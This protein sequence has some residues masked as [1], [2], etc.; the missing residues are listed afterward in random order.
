MSGA[1]VVEVAVSLVKPPLVCT[2]GLSGSGKTS[3]KVWAAP[4]ALWF[5]TPG[6]LITSVSTV[7]YQPQ[8]VVELDVSSATMATLASIMKER[9]K[10]KKPKMVVIDDFSMI[11]NRTARIE[12]SKYKDKRQLYGKIRDLA[13]ELFDEWRYLGIGV[14]VGCHEKP[15][16]WQ[17]NDRGERIKMINTGSP[18]LP[19]QKAAPDMVKAF[20]IC[21]R[22][23]RNALLP[24]W[25]FEYAAGPL[26]PDAAQW[27]SKDRWGRAP[28]GTVVMNLGE[29]LRSI[30]E[31]KA[32][33]FDM[34]RP[35]SCSG[36]EQWVE[37]AAQGILGGSGEQAVLTKM[38]EELVKNNYQRWQIKWAVRDTRARVQIRRSRSM[39]LMVELGLG[40]SLPM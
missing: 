3:D 39:D 32:I 30:D 2:Y 20:D 1:S 16:S 13:A 12:G 40:A 36:L 25:P 21:Y 33:G 18:D 31:Y 35:D 24:M 9:V 6:G 38:V 27:E 15:P 34:P 28:R 37:W 29:I 26:A 14:F 5:C 7:E 22:V 17:E 8:D 19:G 4:D 10:R 11:A 23:T